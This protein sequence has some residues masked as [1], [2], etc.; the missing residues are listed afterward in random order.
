MKVKTILPID[1][2]HGKL[3]GRSEYYFRSIRG[4]QF[5]QRCPVKKRAATDVEKAKQCL[6]G[7]RAKKVARMMLEGVCVSR[8]ELW[9]LVMSEGMN[10]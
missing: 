8:K 3:D 7:K 5:A 4:K 1:A 6:F 9:A 10:E 2:L